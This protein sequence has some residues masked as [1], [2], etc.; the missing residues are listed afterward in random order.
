MTSFFVHSRSGFFIEYGWGGRIID[1]AKWQPHETF[2]GPSLWDHDRTWSPNSGRN[3]AICDC[4]LWPK[5][6]GKNWP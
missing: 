4:G 6:S 1:P 3:F 5:A 2:D